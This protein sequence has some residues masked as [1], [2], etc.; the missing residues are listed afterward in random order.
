MT[1]HTHEPLGDVLLGLNARNLSAQP[2]GTLLRMMASVGFALCLRVWQVCRETHS[3]SCEREAL[4]GLD[5]HLLRDIGLSRQEADQ[6]TGK[7]FWE[8]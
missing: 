1:E 5:T 8:A 7:W 3:R 4:R 2:A 6:E